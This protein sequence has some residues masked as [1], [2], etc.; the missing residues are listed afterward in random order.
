MAKLPHFQSILLIFF[1]LT[2]FPNNH[3]HAQS[4]YLPEA[5]FSR[6]E[7]T[8]FQETS[9]NADVIN[10]IKALDEASPLVSVET[11]CT[12]TFGNPVHLVVISDPAISSLEEAKKAGKPVIYIQANIHPGEVEGKEASMQLMREIVLGP[13]KHLIENQVLLF[14][15]NYNPDGNDQLGENRP[16]Q[17][18][19]PKL[20]GV[21]PNG[22][23]LDLN[24]EGMKAEAVEM[25]GL[26][27]GVFNRWDPALFVDL[28]ADNGSWHG[29][30]VNVAPAFQTV[31]MPEPTQKTNEL[32]EEVMSQVLTRSG[33]PVFWHGYLRMRP[34]EPATFTA[35]SHL[36]RYIANYVGLRN[37]MG[38]L[39]ETFPHDHFEKRV[40]SNY[41]LLQNILEYTNDHATEIND[42]VA[43]ADKQTVEMIRSQA[44][45]IQRGVRYKLTTTYEPVTML[46]RQTVPIES[47]GRWQR[48]RPTGK[49]E[50]IDSVQHF[51][52][53]VPTH[54]ST[55]PR[56]Y[57]FPSTLSQ[58]A[59]KLMEHGIEVKQTEKSIRITG[60]EFIISQFIQNQREGYGGHKMVV[61][62]GEFKSVK[63]RFPAGTYSVDLAQ[64]KAWLAFY[65]LEPQSDDGLAYWNFFDE[66]LIQA[67]V[68]KKAV[69]FP[70]VKTNQALD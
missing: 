15:P 5:L 38:I 52:H 48:V 4:A 41:Y 11:I 47:T 18:G 54:F 68:E 50:Y 46:L 6:A 22:K 53:F 62:E 63:K 69:P 36:P 26:L 45:T 57:L 40:L 66:Y 3:L 58:I 51:N 7:R 35:Y 34:N 8:N 55:V 70:V 29:Y 65:L 61:L 44:G 12:T 16:S 23:G 20:A 49:L 10:F 42:L 67:G 56:T 60:E 9:L 27:Q 19:S 1:A 13:K 25:K 39:S 14:C 59:E 17:E 32:L 30:I 43:N 37:R 33:L 21:R 24:R 64:P 28:H 31:G 2:L